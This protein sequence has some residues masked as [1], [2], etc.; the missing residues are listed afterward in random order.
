[1]P[2]RWFHIQLCALN[3]HSLAI[4]ALKYFG[5]KGSSC[6]PHTDRLQVNRPKCGA[7]SSPKDRKAEN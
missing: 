3:S 7:L 6:I 1:M 4:W 2:P 5:V